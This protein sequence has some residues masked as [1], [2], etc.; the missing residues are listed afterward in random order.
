LTRGG[1]A[2]G[3]ANATIND[4]TRDSADIDRNFERAL[5]LGL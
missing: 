1:E 5:A 2:L 4:P 3:I